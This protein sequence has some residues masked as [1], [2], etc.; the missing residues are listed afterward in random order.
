MSAGHIVRTRTDRM[1][2]RVSP[3][4]LWPQVPKHTYRIVK[5]YP[6][7]ADA[8][9]QPFYGCETD[10]R[11][12]ASSREMFDSYKY[13]VEPDFKSRCRLIERVHSYDIWDDRRWRKHISIYVPCK[14]KRPTRSEVNDFRWTMEDGC[15]ST[16][17]GTFTYNTDEASEVS[18]SEYVEL[19]LLYEFLLKHRVDVMETLID[20]DYAHTGAM[21]FP[22]NRVFQNG[23]NYKVYSLLGIALFES[24]NVDAVR[25]LL[26]RGADPDDCH[27]HSHG[28]TCDRTSLM[29]HQCFHGGDLVIWYDRFN[30]FE[31]YGVAN[32][33]LT[34]LFEY[35]AD[36]LY[37]SFWTN[38]VGNT[39]QEKK[40]IVDAAFDSY[41]ARILQRWHNVLAI[42]QLIAFWRRAAAAPDSKA[43]LKA[44]KRFRALSS[45]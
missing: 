17:R 34:A 15:Y 25:M 12:R 23:K 6:T 27:A 29:I 30:G 45:Y 39:D 8:V 9:P 41:S 36:P 42:V 28:S 14:G 7:L 11:E 26:E 1:D 3:S 19:R 35:G 5:A 22:C 31:E 37:A 43:A 40:S 33:M 21:L 38:T 16:E 24:Q 13:Y 2:G 20:H 18:I 44:A 4:L 32:E 10:P